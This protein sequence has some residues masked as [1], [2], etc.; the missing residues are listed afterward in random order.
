MKYKR[1]GTIETDTI[2]KLTVEDLEEICSTIDKSKDVSILHKIDGLWVQQG[3]SD[4]VEN[5]YKIFNPGV[6]YE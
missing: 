2:L 1:D 3:S 4:M 6:R 5:T